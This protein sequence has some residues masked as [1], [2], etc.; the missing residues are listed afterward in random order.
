MKKKRKK[1]WTLF[2]S[3]FL[4]ASLLSGCAMPELPSLFSEDEEA[5][6]KADDQELSDRQR[7]YGVHIEAV[8]K[9][10]HSLKEQ[11]LHPLTV[12][13][14]LVEK[15]L[16]SLSVQ[17]TEYRQGVKYPRK[18]WSV[19]GKLFDDTALPLLAQGIAAKLGK[20]SDDEEVYFSVKRPFPVEGKTF[21]THSGWYWFIRSVDNDMPKELHAG[22]TVHEWR[23]VLHS[24][25]SYVATSSMYRL[26][27]VNRNWILKPLPQE[28]LN[29]VNAEVNR[30]QEQVKIKKEY[31]E[32]LSSGKN[33]R[34]ASL[35]SVRRQEPDSP[36]VIE[37]KV[38]ILENLRDKGIITE[39]E[40]RVKMKQILQ[41]DF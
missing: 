17:H 5:A 3:G 28:V 1:Q 15:Q 25:D 36:A 4:V 20:I 32:S 30:K 34:A 41:H 24:G 18:N 23:I 26:K 9:G 33:S 13:A 6:Q 14:D 11:Y 7:A 19:A 29:V 35:S 16:A 27:E 21:L 8:L 39:E 12:S 31:E 40:F 37:K 2:L 22:G 10:R 38:H